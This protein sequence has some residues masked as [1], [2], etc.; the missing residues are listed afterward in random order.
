MMMMVMMVVVV[1]M[2]MMTMMMMTM[3]MNDLRM[4]GATDVY[5][6]A[7]P[8]DPLLIPSRWCHQG[9]ITKARCAFTYS[10]GR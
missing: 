7:I 9:F 5:D 6:R 10:V 4:I 2:M 3:M 1:V 8:P